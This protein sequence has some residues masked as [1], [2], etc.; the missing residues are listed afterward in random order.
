M[1][2]E[3]GVRTMG[4]EQNRVKVDIFGQVYTLRGSGSADRLLHFAN[5]VNEKMNELFEQNPRLDMSTLAVLTALNFAEEYEKL[6]DEYDRL[7]DALELEAHQELAN[8][9]AGE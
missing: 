4:A 8:G 6:S 7:L 3:A 9:Q 1:N 5:R 2:I